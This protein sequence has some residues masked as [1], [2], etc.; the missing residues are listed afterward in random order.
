MLSQLNGLKVKNI[1]LI[2]GDAGVNFED[3]TSLCIY[4]RFDLLGFGLEEASILIGST[5]TEAT[6]SES[7][8]VIRFGDRAIQVDLR[9]EAYEGPEAMQLLVPG[10]PIVVWN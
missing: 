1:L 4:N 5:V 9:D 7:S 6:E 8:A 3:G 2:P 10:K